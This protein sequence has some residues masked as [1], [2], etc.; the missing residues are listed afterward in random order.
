[1]KEKFLTAGALVFFLGCQAP[2][3]FDKAA[4]PPAVPQVKRPNV[5][6]AAAA[7][8]SAG[9]G[10][11]D[12]PAFQYPAGCQNWNWT[13]QGSSNLVDWIDLADYGRGCSGP[14][15]VVAPAGRV[16][17]YRMRGSP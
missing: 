10:G 9:A 8:S 16:Y 14:R 1:M 11:F 6:T 4:G 12:L 7:G 3:P 13:L 5:A 17:F 15:A 2:A